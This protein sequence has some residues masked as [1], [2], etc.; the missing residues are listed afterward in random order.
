M[1]NDDPMAFFK[2][3]MFGIMAGAV[4]G[5]LLA[6]KAGKE[7]R[8]DIKKFV[9]EIEDKAVDMYEDARKTLM[10]K[11]AAVKKAGEMID[12]GKYQS[13]VRQVVNEFKKD[14]TVSS[15]VAE[16]LGEQLKGDWLMVKKELQK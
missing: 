14:A 8:E 11:I 15:A 9:G 4:A 7:T 5:I 13:M 16:K 12:E 3:M 10:K 1:R 2:G 6:P